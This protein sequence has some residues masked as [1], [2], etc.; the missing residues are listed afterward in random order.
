MRTAGGFQFSDGSLLPWSGAFRSHLD[1]SPPSMRC[2]AY[3]RPL[4]IAHRP[5]MHRHTLHSASRCSWVRWSAYFSPALGFMLY[6]GCG[7]AGRAQRREGS[8]KPTQPRG[9]A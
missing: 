1:V 3:L 2:C 4:A 8:F 5:V 9:L 7:V 6:P